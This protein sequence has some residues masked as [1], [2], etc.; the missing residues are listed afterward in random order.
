MTVSAA[1]EI[2]EIAVPV[3][4]RRHPAARRF[5]LRIS[6]ARRAVVLTVPERCSLADA[7]TFVRRNAAWVHSHLSDLPT[8]VPFADGVTIPFRGQPHGVRFTCGP[9][10]TGVV[11]VIAARHELPCERLAHAK[12]VASEADDEGLPTLLVHGRPTHAPRRLRDWLVNT[13]RND[14]SAAVQRHARTLQLTPRRI[15][16]RDQSSR[17]G[18]CSSS[19]ALSFSWRLVLAPPLVLDYV[20]AHEVAHLKE[21]NHSSRFW[22]LVQITMPRMDEARVWLRE[23]GMTLHAFG[24]EPAER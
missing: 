4:L 1:L 22:D 15:S 2:P 20:A 13:A 6:Q 24:V 17:W 5:T 9:R 16:V 14:L 3:E 19:G 12:S 8:A 18:S 11:E 10:R 23:H 21:M 7:E